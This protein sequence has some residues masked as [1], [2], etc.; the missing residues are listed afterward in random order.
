MD[1]DLSAR[2]YSTVKFDNAMR[3]VAEV[4]DDGKNAK[5]NNDR[6]NFV[7]NILGQARSEWFYVST[8]CTL[9]WFYITIPAIRNGTDSE[10]SNQNRV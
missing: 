1:V 9:K 10:T 2:T 4:Y 8:G 7:S 5:L 3:S 6:L